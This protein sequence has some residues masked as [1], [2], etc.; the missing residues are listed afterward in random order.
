MSE[1]FFS[2][3]DLPD[4]VKE[5]MRAAYERH[6]MEHDV[7]AHELVRALME[8]DVDHLSA[9]HRILGICKDDTTAIAYY[10]GVVSVLRSTRTKLCLACGKNH[11]EALHAMFQDE[12]G[13][14]KADPNAPATPGISPAIAGQDGESDSTEL[15]DADR[16]DLMELYNLIQHPNGRIFCGGCG[17][18]Y[19]S[20]EDR[21]LREPGP[22]GCDSCQQKAKW[23]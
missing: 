8:M 22:A 2:F 3:D 9:L 5:S 4:E 23:G 13:A 15:S 17:Q 21:M 10:I 6:Q 19:V 12:S 11:D 14:P 16:A 18:K 7:V 1:H 20:L